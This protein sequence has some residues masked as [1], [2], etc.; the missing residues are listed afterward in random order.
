MIRLQGISHLSA[1]GEALFK[2]VT[3]YLPSDRRMAV[4]GG[5][6]S[7]KSTLI[8]LL[9][10][11]VTPSSGRIDRYARLSFPAGYL[12]GFRQPQSVRQN[13]TFAARI[14]NADPEEV[15]NFVREVTGLG[16]LMSSRLRD[17]PPQTRIRL[18]YA[19]AYALP[20][21]TYLFD[22][23]ISSG[24]EPEFRARCEA[25][26]RARSETSGTIVATHRSRLAAQHCDCAVIIREG[27]LFYYDDIQDAV[28]FFDQDL[29]APAGNMQPTEPEDQQSLSVTEAQA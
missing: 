13:V 25:M 22:N 26:Y 18:S 20:F 10:G 6:Q 23:G 14:Y 16:D 4:L 17:L 29:S 1:S 7:G 5:P 19:L 11:V 8:Q 3:L 24:S 12:R 9:A 15:C 27:G 2:D 28:A 21:D